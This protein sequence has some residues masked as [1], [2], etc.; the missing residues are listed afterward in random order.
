MRKSYLWAGIF[1]LAIGGW[2]ASPYL[3]PKAAETPETK[4]AGEAAEA[5]QKLFQVRVKTF[6]AQMR[7]AAVTAR[8]TTEPS[9]DV[10]VRAR[11]NGV[12]VEQPFKQGAIVKAGD[13]L[14]GLDMM[15]R[16]S[17]LAQAEAA[18]A[19][20]QRDYDAT[21]KLVKTGVAPQNR[22]VTQQAAL[23]AA[24]AAL[25]LVKWDIGQMAIM[26]PVTGVLIAKP[27]EAG[28]LLAPGDLC[29]TIAVL[30]P[31][32]VSTQVS[33]QFVNY[34]VPGMAARAKLATGEE[35]QGKVRFI[36]Q[37]SDLATRTFKVELEVP[38]PGN[39]LRAGVTSEI[40]VPLP[41]VSAQFLPA[42][43]LGLNDKGQFGVR[44]LNADDTTTFTEVTLI[45][46]EKA[47]AWVSGLPA[48]ARI[49]VVGQDYVRDGEKVEP[50][51]EVAGSNS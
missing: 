45:A 34:V 20:A 15:N 48:E 32:V 3:M 26:A 16:A 37:S 12:I 38:N 43:V 28:S 19:S 49:V 21:E 50:V 46:Q 23:D 22:L 10:E 6:K 31:I 36:A 41:P 13:K 1:T 5:A 42:S 30:D 51:V 11:T 44:L 9:A 4:P 40:I 14:C 35:V 24:Q 17:Q 29:A 7:E 27:A 8:G 2:L 39:R 33:E 47:G 25:V 18:V